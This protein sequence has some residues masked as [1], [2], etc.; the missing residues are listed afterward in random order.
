MSFRVP[1]IPEVLNRTRTCTGS[2]TPSTWTSIPSSHR[3]HR[4]ALTSAHHIT[5]RF[6]ILRLTLMPSIMGFS[7]SLVSV[8]F[9]SFG[10]GMMQRHDVFRCLNA[11]LRGKLAIEA[12]TS[13][14]E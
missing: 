7:I 6:T 4:L 10:P 11:I 2:G 13:P 3:Y 5:L 12:Y 14:T 8:V 9:G 1:G